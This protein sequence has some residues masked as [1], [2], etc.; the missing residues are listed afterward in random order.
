MCLILY[1]LK[2]H[3]WL[4]AEVGRYL[5]GFI[6]SPLELYNV[7]LGDYCVDLEGSTSV[8]GAGVF[9]PARR[10]MISRMTSRMI[11]MNTVQS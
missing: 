1:T 4:H 7:Y 11:G 2:R 5:R 6:T 9:F 10:S 8:F 3:P